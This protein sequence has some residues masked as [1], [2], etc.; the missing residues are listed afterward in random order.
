MIGSF[1]SAK[2]ECKARAIGNDFDDD[3]ALLCILLA[4]RVART[5]AHSG[6]VLCKVVRVGA[7]TLINK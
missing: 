7:R 4:L 1:A 3:V 5:S 6:E 2:V